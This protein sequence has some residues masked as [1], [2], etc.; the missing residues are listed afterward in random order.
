[1]FN[2]SQF[3]EVVQRVNQKTPEV[4]RK[5]SKIDEEVCRIL[6]DLLLP[7]E[8]ASIIIYAKNEIIKLA[9]E[10]LHIMHEVIEGIGAPIKMWQNSYSWE[11]LRGVASGTAVDVNALG[12]IGNWSGGAASAYSTAV[13]PQAG[14]AAQL[15]S[16]AD[17]VSSSLTTSAEAGA[18][19]Y[20]A[21][22]AS[23]VQFISAEASAVAGAATVV[24]TA[25]GLLAGLGGGAGALALLLG[26][27]SLIVSFIATMATQMSTLH[28]L[29]VD[30]TA[31][32]FGRWP[33]AANI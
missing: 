12:S 11:T 13:G 9:E 10:F 4:A 8:V 6:N 32:P 28:G 7:P 17:S 22:A 27:V 29:A 2:A 23:L 26:A 33:V 16:I 14:A 20:L 21:V 5:A 1:M 18:A 30:S 19:F 15:A 25:P 24:G 3:D 31:F